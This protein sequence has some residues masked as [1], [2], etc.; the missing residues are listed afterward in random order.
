MRTVRLGREF[1]AVFV[2][3]AIGYMTTVADLRLALETAFVHCRRGGAALFAPDHVSETYRPATD[4]GGHD[5]GTRGLRY[6]EWSWDPDPDD[7][8]CFTEYAYLL[9]ED[10][11]SVRVEYE[12]HVEGLFPRAVWLDLMVRAGFVAESAPFEHSE[13]EPGAL[14]VFVGRR[15]G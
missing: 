10:D 5:A 7:S 2:H 9:R 11:G 4:H 3:D 13:F 15:P 8:T 6:L 14:E 1:D 12:R